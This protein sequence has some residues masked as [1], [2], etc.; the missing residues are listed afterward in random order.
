MKVIQAGEAHM[1]FLFSF[2]LPCGRPGAA[3]PNRAIKEPGSRLPPITELETDETSSFQ[4][5]LLS[6]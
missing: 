4:H 5:L 3:E 1:S 2:L 6:Y